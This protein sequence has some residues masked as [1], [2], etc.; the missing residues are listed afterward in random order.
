MGVHDEKCWST[1]WGITPGFIRLAAGVTGGG[2][3][4]GVETNCGITKLDGKLRGFNGDLM[5][6]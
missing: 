6:I 5:V 1:H 4:A 3:A 2:A